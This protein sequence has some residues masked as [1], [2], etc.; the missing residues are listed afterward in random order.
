MRFP[1]LV[2]SAMRVVLSPL[3]VSPETA[4][5]ELREDE[6]HVCLGRLFDERYPL[7]AVAEVGHAEHPWWG[8]LGVR[9]MGDGVVAA[10]GSLSNVVAVRFREAQKAHVIV[11]VSCQ[12]LR[13][14]LE[15]PE[16]FV[17]AL[18]S[19]LAARR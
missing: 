3:G 9:L 13:V 2:N 18:R 8:G 4:Y 17:N 15:E 19:S 5:V 16:A 11:V 14:S 10:V 7:A 6:L 1:I 12:E